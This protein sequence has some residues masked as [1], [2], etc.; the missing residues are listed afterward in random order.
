MAGRRPKPTRIKEIEGNP[1]KRPL[2]RQEPHPEPEIPACPEHLDDE[3]RAEWGRIAPQLHALGVLAR[4]DRAALAA[5]CMCWSRW[6][7]A[8]TQLRKFGTVIKTAKGY[9]IQNPYLGIANTAVDQM[10]KFMTEFGMTPSSRSRVSASG[11]DGGEEKDDPWQQFLSPA[12]PA[13]KVN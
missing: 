9:P 10:R 3:A 4:V 13:A 1:G 2:N 5:Y 11:G 8:E 12:K 7:E 6:V